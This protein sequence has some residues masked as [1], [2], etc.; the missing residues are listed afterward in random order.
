LTFKELFNSIGSLIYGKG[1]ESTILMDADGFA[2]E[3]FPFDSN[4]FEKEFS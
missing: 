1:D 4:P 3:I 2:E